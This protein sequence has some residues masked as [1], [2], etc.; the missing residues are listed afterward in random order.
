[1]VDERGDVTRTTFD[2]LK[3]LSDRF[4]GALAEAGVTRG[5]R[6]AVFLPQRIECAV[7]HLA[8][9]KLGACS[10]PPSPLFRHAALDVRLR[11]SGAKVVVTDAEHREHL[12]RDFSARIIACD[13][14]ASTP[15]VDSFWE[16]L[17]D[18]KPARI[19]ETAADDPAMVV[20]TS[21]T[22][23]PPKGAVHAHRF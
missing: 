16:L 9:F 18:T 20:Y 6:V 4:A 5:D 21:G 3:D 19:A 12:P 17:R 15:G 11:H 23:G 10:V 13:E 7:A 14:R 22:S 2:E 8:T 1:A